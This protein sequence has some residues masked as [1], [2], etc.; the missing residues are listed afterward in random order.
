VLSYIEDEIAMAVSST[1]IE[2][3]MCKCCLTLN[4]R[5]Q[6]LSSAQVLKIRLQELD[7]EIATTV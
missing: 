3:E 6:E 7:E 2:K 5:L 4:M 1:G